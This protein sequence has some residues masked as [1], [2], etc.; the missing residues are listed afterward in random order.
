MYPSEAE[1]SHRYS[2]WLKNKEHIDSHN[3]RAD[4]HGF[5]LALNKFSDLKSSEFSKQFNGYKKPLNAPK[6]HTK[7]FVPTPGLQLPDNVDW[8]SKKVVTGVKD[9]GQCGSCWAFS[10]T[11]VLEG[12]HALKTGNLVSL[13]EQNLVDCST[14][15]NFGCAGGLTSTAYVYIMRN[16]GIDT[17]DSYPYEARNGT[18]RFNSRNVGATLYGAVMV[19]ANEA[20][21]QEAAATVG[22]ISV[23]IDASK[24]SFQSYNSGVYYEPACS[25]MA[26]DHCVLVVGYGVSNGGRAYWL[27]KNSWGSA[28]GQGGYILMSRNMNNNCGIATDATYPTV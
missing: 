20:A 22:P 27:V 12:Q 5:T 23:C 18:C 19:P 16:G 7:P 1:E 15:F 28:W 25:P 11:G 6:V 4:Q 9:Q 21:L 8:R 24:P 17:E 3:A 26:L 2:V 10:T 13:S 14:I